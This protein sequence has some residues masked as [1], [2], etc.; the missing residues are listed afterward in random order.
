M[1]L[2]GTEETRNGIVVTAATGAPVLVVGAP[3][4]VRNGWPTDADGRL[5]TVNV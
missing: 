5:A 1:A 3:T 4:Q 2:T